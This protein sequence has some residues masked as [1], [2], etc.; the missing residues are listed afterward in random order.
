MGTFTLLVQAAR[1]CINRRWDT[2]RDPNRISG[3]RGPPRILCGRPTQNVVMFARGLINRGV[4][5]GS[6]KIAGVRQNA[7]KNKILPLQG[8]LTLIG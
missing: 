1:W 7:K 2:L 5:S 4:T 3:W 6:G 8:H